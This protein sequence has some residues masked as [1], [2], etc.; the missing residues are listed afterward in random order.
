VVIWKTELDCVQPTSELVVEETE[1]EVLAYATEE[2]LQLVYRK[3]DVIPAFL[4]QV[5]DD[6]VFV[7]IQVLQSVKTAFTAM[8]FDNL[9][10]KFKT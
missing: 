8:L 6:E 5:F 3:L 7:R 1:V 9:V 10:L 2:L 4:N